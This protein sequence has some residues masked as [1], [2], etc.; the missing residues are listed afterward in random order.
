MDG[1]SPGGPPRGQGR[2]CPCRSCRRPEP[3]PAGRARGGPSPRAELLCARIRGRCAFVHPTRRRPARKKWWKE[4]PILDVLVETAGERLEHP[5]VHVQLLALAG[6]DSL[7]RV[8]DELLVGEL[9]L[10]A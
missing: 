8:F 1:L 7:R 5:R 4:W 2:W 6:D 3:G 10:C 9:A